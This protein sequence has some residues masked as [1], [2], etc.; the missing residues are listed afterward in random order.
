[1]ESTEFAAQ[2]SAQAVTPE[3]A[4]VQTTGD[5]QQEES[6]VI[7]EGSATSTQVDDEPKAVKEL[8][9]QRKK[10]QDA[11]KEAAYWKGVAEA[12]QPVQQAVQAPVQQLQV[13]KLEDFEDYE[14]YE[15]A[16]ED[17]LISKA[18]ER[19]AAK[20]QQQQMQQRMIQQHTAFQERLSAAVEEDPE[21]AEYVNDR[22]LTISNPMLE[23]IR[24]SEVAPQLI[25]YLGQNR[26]EAQKIY[27]MSPL[28]AARELGKLEERMIAKPKPEVKRVS[29]APKPIQPVTLSGSS[30]VDEASLSMEEWARRRNEAQYGRKR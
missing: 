10:R 6:A 27:N 28:A 24:E 5:S 8:K 18:E 2:E 19:A 14:S 9:A 21:I 22:S 11:E 25:K 4:P 13:P 17:Y 3:S 16:K 26:K 15:A 29:A 7:T 20:I 12:K 23:V 30:S 1:M